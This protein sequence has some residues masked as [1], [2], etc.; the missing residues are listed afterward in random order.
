M[1]RHLDQIVMKLKTAQKEIA[2]TPSCFL[3]T[4]EKIHLNKESKLKE[5]APLMADPPPAT[6]SLCTVGFIM[7]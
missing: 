1:P 6:P 7:I 3:K 5:V 2:D 4:K